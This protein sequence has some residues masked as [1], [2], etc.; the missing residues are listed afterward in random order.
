M[1]QA[2]AINVLQFANMMSLD[3]QDEEVRVAFETAAL[4]RV[5][6]YRPI[7]LR[8]RHRH[9]GS[10]VCLTRSARGGWMRSSF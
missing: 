2:Y 4:L 9:A 8:P 7:L 5:A 6:P 10:S 3:A 1:T